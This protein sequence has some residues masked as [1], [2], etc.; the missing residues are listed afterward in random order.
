[1]SNSTVV[2][3]LKRALTKRRRPKCIQVF[4]AQDWELFGSGPHCLYIDRPK[5]KDDGLGGGAIIGNGPM[6]YD[7]Y[8]FAGWRV[9]EESP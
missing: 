3:E 2:K 6:A 1:M 7:P 4:F 9:V 8:E 5:W